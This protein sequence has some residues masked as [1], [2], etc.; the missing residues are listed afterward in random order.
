MYMYL[1]NHNLLLGVLND[2]KSI[3]LNNFQQ[4]MGT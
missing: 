2:I 3:N 4:P 1:G